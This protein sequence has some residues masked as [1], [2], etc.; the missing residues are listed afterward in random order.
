M[1]NKN[2]KGQAAMEFLMTYG[3]AILVVLASI[4]A[5]AY[6]GVLSPDKF[7]PE[8]CIIAPGIDCSDFNIKSD[9]AVFSLKNS[10]G[11]NYVINSIALGDN[12][13]QDFDP[14]LNFNNGAVAK[15]ELTGCSNGEIGSKFD[16]DI[17]LRFYN[18]ESDIEKLILEKFCGK[19][20]IL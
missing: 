20:L 15:L 3:W 5:L 2:K 19:Y 12:C 16:G 13:S 18:S 1:F 7:L 6:F 10:M 17:S 14:A 4:A 11:K 8:K 9:S